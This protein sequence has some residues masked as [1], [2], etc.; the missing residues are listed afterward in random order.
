MTGSWPKL[1]VY[2]YML[3]M[4]LKKYF[5]YILFDICTCVRHHQKAA[6]V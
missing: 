1:S 4:F 6:A 2:M 5:I 3:S